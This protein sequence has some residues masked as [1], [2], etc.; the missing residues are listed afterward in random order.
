MSGAGNPAP[1]AR[2][3]DSVEPLAPAGSA[4]HATAATTPARSATR[5]DLMAAE[6]TTRSETCFVSADGSGR[7]R[8]LSPLPVHAAHQMRQS[9]LLGG[10]AL[11][12]VLL[13]ARRGRVREHLVGG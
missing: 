7:R 8:G 3:V 9:H 11:L 13:A 5:I 2:A 1:R 10:R 12:N 4:D 6:T